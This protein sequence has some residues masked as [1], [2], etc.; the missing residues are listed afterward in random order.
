[1]IRRRD[2]ISEFGRSR[3]G[4]EPVELPEIA[5]N[6]EVFRLLLGLLPPRSSPEEKRV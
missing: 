1:M 4:V 5:E 2:Y 6:R 3:L